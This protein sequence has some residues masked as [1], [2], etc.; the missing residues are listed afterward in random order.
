MK[1]R[2][3]LQGLPGTLIIICINAIAFLIT[4]L[5]GADLWKGNGT[6]LLLSGGNY[7][8]LTIEQHQYW[9]LVTSMFLHAG[10]G[11]LV[12][13]MTGLFIGG[14]FLEPVLKSWRFIILYLV[15]GLI[16]DFT[17]IYF[18]QLSIGVGASGAIFGIYG[19]FIALLSTSLFPLSFR[20]A[21]LTYIGLFVVL[22][23]VT[24]IL[25]A[26]MD[27]IA[28]LGG[29]LAGALLGYGCY[30]TLTKEDGKKIIH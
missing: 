8:P 10:L 21:F 24:A 6:I 15:T 14:F 9:R 7:W 13:N 30:F 29:F 22:N 16:A 17:S 20:K 27:N 1:Q 11:H 12:A 28:H 2:N 23:V 4:T 19:V 25:A 18:H 5:K 3:K 26:D